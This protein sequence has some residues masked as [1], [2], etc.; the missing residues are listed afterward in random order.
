[1]KPGESL[2]LLAL[3]PAI[4]DRWIEELKAP[5]RHYHT[6]AHVE[7]ILSQYRGTSREIIAA[8]WLHDI[9]Y[10]PRRH[11]NEEVSAEIAIRCLQGT[12]ID[13][14]EV[15]RIILDTKHHQGGDPTLDLFC[16]LDLS[17]IGA[18]PSIYAAYAANIRKEYAFVE[19]QA[20]RAARASILTSFNARRVFKTEGF[21]AME[22]QAHA[23]LAWEMA[24]L[25][26]FEQGEV[27][28]FL[29]R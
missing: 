19:E 11:D 4:T 12:D 26:G 5:H 1:M 20:Y 27:V 8:A 14:S 28:N 18:S 6:L 22:D 13:A 7:A 23:N 3:D 29:S 9:R 16:D 15:E 25:L 10:D 2:E 24:R 17:I 21:R